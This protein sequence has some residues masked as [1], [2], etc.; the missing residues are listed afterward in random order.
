MK[1]KRSRQTH[2]VDIDTQKGEHMYE[3]Q[4]AF[5]AHFIAVSR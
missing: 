2:S 5:R 3:V 4:L 1:L